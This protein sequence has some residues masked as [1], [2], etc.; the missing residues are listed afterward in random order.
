MESDYSQ[1]GF[2]FAARL[3]GSDVEILGLIPNSVQG[4]AVIVPY[5]E[6]LARAAR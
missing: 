4:D 6:Q 2:Y 1:A 5:A 3:L